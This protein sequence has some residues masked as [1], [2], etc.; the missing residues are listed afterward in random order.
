MNPSPHQAKQKKHLRLIS[1]SKLLAITKY[2]KLKK[3]IQSEP[4]FCLKLIFE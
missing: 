4:L 1:V 3:A 2:K